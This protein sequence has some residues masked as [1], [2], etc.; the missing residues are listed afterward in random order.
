MPLFYFALKTGRTTIPDPEGQELA[1]EAAARLHARVVAQQLIRHREK[2]S[3][4]WRIQICDDYLRPV[5]EVFFA[6]ID[7]SFAAAPSQL[8]AS[9][10]DVTRMVAALDDSIVAMQATL[11]DARATLVKADLLLASMPRVRL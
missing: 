9:I 10:E 8:Q 3:R 2:D 7:E 1:D 4:G 6:E 5:S 11:T